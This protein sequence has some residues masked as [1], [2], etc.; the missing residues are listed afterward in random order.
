MNSGSIETALCQ[1]KRIRYGN[2]TSS[3]RKDIWVER[4]SGR[5]YWETKNGAKLER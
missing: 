3:I 1:G 4:I 2:Q 5:K